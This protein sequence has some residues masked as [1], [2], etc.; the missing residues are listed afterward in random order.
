MTTRPTRGFGRRSTLS[1]IERHQ[2]SNGIPTVVKIILGMIVIALALTAQV[3]C[4]RRMVEVVGEMQTAAEDAALEKSPIHRAMKEHEPEEYERLKNRI[5]VTSK[6]IMASRRVA[7]QS[8]AEITAPLIKKYMPMASEAAVLRFG[9]ALLRQLTV[10]GTKSPE[11]AWKVLFP[12]PTDT[13]DV[14]ENAVPPDLEEEMQWS[15]ADLISTGAVGRPVHVDPDAF[16]EIMTTVFADMSDED[17][18]T[19]ALL[20]N[21][22]DRA[23]DRRASVYAMRAYYESILALPPSD[24]V[25]VLRKILG[26]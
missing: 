20:R 11:T 9:R 1:R 13:I 4:K 23:I 18:E 8:M 25:L 15:V 5:R 7:P 14:V 6:D 10:L 2:R 17:R 12:R 21:P 26:N 22:Y 19:L 3:M 24:A 16:Q